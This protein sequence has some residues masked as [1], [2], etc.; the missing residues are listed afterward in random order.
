MRRNCCSL[1]G[2]VWKRRSTVRLSDRWRSG[3][4]KSEMEVSAGEVFRQN[5]PL[6]SKD[7]FNLE[8]CSV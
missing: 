6:L 4:G 8:H 1:G 5:K 7:I 3:K 2:S